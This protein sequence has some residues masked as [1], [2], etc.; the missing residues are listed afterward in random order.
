MNRASFR[1]T[2]TPPGR[3]R[4]RTL[5]HGVEGTRLSKTRETC[6]SRQRWL[7]RALRTC[8]GFPVHA[9]LAAALGLGLS[10]VESPAAAATNAPVSATRSQ[11]GTAPAE[12]STVSTGE[13]KATKGPALQGVRILATRSHAQCP[14]TGN[15]IAVLS[16]DSAQEWAQ[17]WS[18]DE[19]T[20]AGRP[21]RWSREQVLVYAMNQQ[22]TQ[23]VSVEPAGKVLTLN[24]G[25]LFWPVH[26]IRPAPDQSV[27]KKPSRPCLVAVVKRSY[28]QRIRIVRKN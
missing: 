17:T 20:L 21:I 23:G 5:A 24:S 10:S 7:R 25:V 14:L 22:P 27:T 8:S 19:V 15:R 28:F 12:P 11:A 3:Q 18:Q 2:D 6:P 4:R 26:E 1:A 16:I 13:R 9:V